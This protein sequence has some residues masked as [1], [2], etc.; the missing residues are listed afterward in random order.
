MIE[1]EI[2][3]YLPERKR[4][5]KSKVP[6]HEIVNAILYKLKTGIQWEYLPV[7]SLFSVEVLHYKTVFGHY[8]NWCKKDV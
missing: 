8:R 7:E 2:V 4:G 6:L 1:L 3:P 5:F